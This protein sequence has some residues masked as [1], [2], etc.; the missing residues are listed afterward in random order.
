MWYNYCCTNFIVAQVLHKPWEERTIVLKWNPQDKRMVPI[1][2][3]IYVKPKSQ[4]LCVVDHSAEST[5]WTRTCTFTVYREFGAHAQHYWYNVNASCVYIYIYILYNVYYVNLCT[6]A[7]PGPNLWSLVKD[8]NIWHMIWVLVKPI[9]HSWTWKLV[10]KSVEYLID[11]KED[12]LC[13]CSRH[14]RQGSNVTML[15]FTKCLIKQNT[16]PQQLWT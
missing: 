13:C 6:L 2:R 8:C 15:F 10:Y 1:V 7:K 9:W 11:L 16:N 4:D 12:I 14:Y 5:G 3:L